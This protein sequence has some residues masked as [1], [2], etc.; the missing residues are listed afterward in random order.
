MVEIVVA[1]EERF[2][3]LIPDDDAAELRTVG[4]ALSY[5]NK[6]AVPA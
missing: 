1:A 5:I 4:D 2:G 3:I 6:A